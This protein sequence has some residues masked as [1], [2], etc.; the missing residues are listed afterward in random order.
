[1]W[2]AF[3]ILIFLT[4]PVIGCSRLPKEAE[5]FLK[6]AESAAT[7][8]DMGP[9]K[10]E[11]AEKEAKL[12]DLLTRIPIDAKCF[13]ICK[14]ISLDVFLGGLQNRER[15][16]EFHKRSESA[17]KSHKSI[18]DIPETVASQRTGVELKQ[19]SKNIREE[20]EKACSL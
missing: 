7:L 20:I 6:E 17:T 13:D 2:K 1:M 8:L 16:E 11:W 4:L 19:T 3:S 5:T 9:S 18:V 15:I 12:K 10:E 14:N